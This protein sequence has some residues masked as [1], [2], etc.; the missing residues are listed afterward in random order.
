MFSEL[1]IFED[2]FSPTLSGMI[3]IIDTQGILQELPLEGAETIQVEFNTP[4]VSED[5]KVNLTFVVYK[6]TDR[7]IVNTHK[8]V[9]NLHFFSEE[10]FTDSGMKIS[11]GYKGT[12][13]SVASSILTEM[14][15]KKKRSFNESSNSITFAA[16][17]WGPFKI[18][19]YFTAN[20][21]S[22]V[23]QASN[24][25]F[26]ETTRGF[27]L[28]SL[29]DLY[30]QSPRWDYYYDANPRRIEG[31]KDIKAE[32]SAVQEIYFYP[33]Y[34]ELERIDAGMH[35]NT[36]Y[37]HDITSKTMKVLRYKYQDTFKKGE[38]THLGKF[39]L[40]D[41]HQKNPRIVT[42]KNTMHM[43]FDS[44]QYDFSGYARNKRKPLL[45]DL[46]MLRLDLTVHGRS[47]LNV[48]DVI[49]L[50]MLK[51]TE[52]GGEEKNSDREDPY[53]S[54]SYIITAINHRITM[55]KHQMVIQVSKN[56]ANRNLHGVKNAT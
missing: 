49:N 28:F 19:S 32:Y 52:V 51:Y 15:S 31:K 46:E 7:V 1:N 33:H 23:N 22:P 54:G 37:V 10:A 12:A 2:I 36:S 27:Q 40:V 13:S 45:F 47:E 9:Y 25:M 48:G 35:E 38:I 18:I 3:T 5:Q 20:S 26:F 21:I 29:D 8:Q 4:Q 53:Y 24:F 55:N 30:K 14:G 44:M 17:F 56:A 50:H 41:V 6:I 16:P 34:D 39:P 43:V 42:H 11:K